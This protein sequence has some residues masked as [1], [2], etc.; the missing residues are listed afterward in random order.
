MYICVCAYIVFTDIYY[1]CISIHVYAC[2]FIYLLVGW[3]VVFWQYL[4]CLCFFYVLNQK[5]M[6]LRSN[7][8][9]PLRLQKHSTLL[10]FSGKHSGNHSILQPKVQ[11]EKGILNTILLI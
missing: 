8:H 9:V 10:Y 7:Y 1:I 2:I 4:V 3:P 5:S 11:D 6:L